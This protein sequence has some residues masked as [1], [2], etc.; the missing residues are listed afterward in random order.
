MKPTIMNR[1]AAASLVGILLPTLAGAATITI[2]NNDGPNEGFNDPTPASPVGGNSGTT[3][4]QQRLNVFNKAAE[5]WGL[6]IESAVTIGRQRLDRQH[7]FEHEPA[8]GS[9]LDAGEAGDAV[10]GQSRERVSSQRELEQRGERVAIVVVA[11]VDAVEGQPV[12]V[13]G[14]V[15]VALGRLAIERHL[16]RELPDRAP[17]RD[18]RMV[19]TVMRQH[20]GA[21]LRVGE[22]LEHHA[23]E[24]VGLLFH[25][26]N[27]E[28]PAQLFVL[29]TQRVT[30]DQEAMIRRS[31][32][33]QCPVHADAAIHPF[34]H[35]LQ[36]QVEIRQKVTIF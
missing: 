35:H 17:A 12:D 20:L 5:M 3:V 24:Q 29:H 21:Q 4:G 14:D 16:A 1:I 33:E 27:L 26:F 32:G 23:Q 8:V 31:Q 22:V 28:T 9:G 11:V 10:A 36:H 25:G 2:Q 19:G 15:P 13:A 34:Q 18:R 6:R 30:S 7:H